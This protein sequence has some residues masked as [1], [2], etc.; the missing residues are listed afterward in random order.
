MA[1]FF[2]VSQSTAKLQTGQTNIYRDSQN[3]VERIFITF[4]HLGGALTALAA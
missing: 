2:S 3:V 1:C 4:L